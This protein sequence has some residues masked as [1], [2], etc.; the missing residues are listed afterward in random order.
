[1]GCLASVQPK[2]RARDSLNELPEEPVGDESP[3]PQQPCV[4][5]DLGEMQE[6]LGQESLHSAQN[7]HAQ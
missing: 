7:L 4:P 2:Q 5:E 6:E 1:M 3:S